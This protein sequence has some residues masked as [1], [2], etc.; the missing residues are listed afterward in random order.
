MLLSELAEVE[1]VEVDA[2]KIEAE[3]I[4]EYRKITGRIPAQSDPVR[5][6][7]KFITNYVVHLKAEIN[8]AGKQNLLKYATGNNL[9]NLG[10]FWAC[11]R[12]GATSAQ[13]TMRVKL[14]SARETAT[15]IKAGTR[16]TNGEVEFAT[17]EE[18]IIPA[19]E[20]E[21]TVMASCTQLGTI[22]NDYAIGEL[23]E[24]VNPIAFVSEI[25]N[26]SKTNGGSEEEEDE[27]YRERVHL[28]PEKLSIAGPSRAYAEMAKSLNSDITDAAVDS[29]SPGIVR[30]MP[31]LK[32]AKSPSSEL[33]NKI[34]EYL[35]ADERRPLTDKVE[36]VSP[37]IKEKAL[38]IS[39][40]LTKDADMENIE[41]ALNNAID[42]YKEWQS[43]KLGRDINPN[44]LTQKLMNVSGIKRIEIE[45]P[46]YEELTYNEVCRIEGIEAKLG[47]VEDD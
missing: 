14:S 35:S 3:I 28:S 18:L 38:K 6:F 9:D 16:I 32:G 25:Y 44:K 45:S 22:G 20:S 30:V 39:Y 19:G 37:T 42:E 12:I 40:W 10:V 8:E 21:S 2:E 43:A 4:G 41:E 11:E 34:E 7:L 36:V 1:L 13:T 24:V 15:V 31:M 23:N 27:A 46:K 29:P 5:L 26:I 47:G 33:L 17:D